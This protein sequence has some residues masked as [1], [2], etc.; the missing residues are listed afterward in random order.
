ME[1]LLL[2]EFDPGPKLKGLSLGWSEIATG[3]QKLEKT[4]LITEP[5]PKAN[6]FVNFF[7]KKSFIKKHLAA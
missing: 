5:A 3:G 2:I 1:Y 7:S 6:Q 4:A